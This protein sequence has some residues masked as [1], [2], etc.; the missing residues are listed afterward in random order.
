LSA[1]A[2]RTVVARAKARRAGLPFVDLN[3]TAVDRAAAISV[4]YSL[5]ER[6]RALPYRLDGDRL[7]VA[8]ANPDPAVIDELKSATPHR[9]ELA[10]AA[11]DQ[12]D[13]LLA[14][15]S[16]LEA[17]RDSVSVDGTYEGGPGGGAVL[18]GALAEGV[19]L[20]ASDL[21]LVPKADGLAVKV[22]V[23]GV[24][25]D[26]TTVDVSQA[27]QWISR[28]KVLAKLDIAEHRKPQDGRFSLSTRSARNFDA[29]V[30]VLPTVA[31]EG[32][33]IR[34][35]ETTRTAPSLSSIGLSNEMQMSFERL[36]N[37]AD[38]AILA[39]GPTG[40]GK[41]TTLYA[42]LADISRPEINVITVEDPV[43]Y[44]LD[45]AYQIQ[46]DP[47]AELTFSSALRSVLRGDPDV[48]MVGEIRD[49]ETARMTM[50]AA[51]T[52]H[53]VL[54]TLHATD[55]PAA[56]IRLVEMGVEGHTLG[57]GLT[58]VLAQR[59]V[60][61]LCVHCRRPYQP[62]P[63]E[64][65]LLDRTGAPDL[66]FFR[67][68]GCSLCSRGYR[69]RIGVFQLLPLSRSIAH[70]AATGADHAALEGAAFE[71]GM[72]TLWSDG[73]TKVETGV[74]SVEELRRVLA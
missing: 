69:G 58:A 60:R 74:T 70:L 47:R 73:L 39:V 67:A 25:R 42:A 34:L 40:S 18:D 35:L 20:G 21:H 28:L 29:R 72:G 49:G 1:A 44:A 38:G 3:A 9:L 63:D 37:R 41:S 4:P 26:V 32:A 66:S 48:L 13:A 31:G 45:G 5:L 7:A 17:Q 53:R 24:M 65:E 71:E 59:L 12:V 2:E 10:V 56:L 51:L 61:R 11:P 15:S 27:P 36:M 55:A 22:R 64:L 68:S 33:V 6:V 23:D 16:P 30:V 14:A 19:A 8:L 54:A 43:E 52:G 50:N 46:I 57:A 62:T